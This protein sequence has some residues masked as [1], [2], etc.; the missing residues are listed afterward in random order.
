MKQK[1][2]ITG[3]IGSGKSTA[4]QCLK[5]LGYP[6]FSC[7]EVYK[8]VIVSPVYVEKIATRFPTCVQEGKIDRAILAALVFKK[9][10][11][12]L[13][14]NAIAHPLI[15]QALHK[16][17]DEVDA[18]LVFAEVPLLFEGN[19]QNQ[20]DKIIVVLRERGARISAVVQRDVLSTQAVESRMSA[21]F[22]YASHYAQELFKTCNAILIYNNTTKEELKEKIKNSIASWT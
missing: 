5:E 17:M 20:F 3:G 13:A 2:A 18:E 21:Q 11:E 22:D 16:K 12:R 4:L 9:K 7:D 8:E 19:Y 15:M 6:V 1:I 10:E 14:L